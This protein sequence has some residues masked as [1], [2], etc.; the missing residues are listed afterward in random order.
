MA[1]A[2]PTVMPVS[3]GVADFA[4]LV[5]SHQGMVFS[6]AYHFLHDWATAEE[7]AQDVFVQLCSSL[8]KLESPEHILFWLR[9]TTV[10]RC[11]D[12]VR[13]TRR[14]QEVAIE[15]IDEVAAP[16]S[17]E[18]DEWM[19]RRLRRF[20]AAL[21]EDAR[22]CVILRYQEGLEPREIAAVMKISANTVKSRLQR[23]LAL[24]REKAGVE[25]MSDE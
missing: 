20:V 8:K 25:R 2:L 13:R 15:T 1:M 24:L 3:T 6:I 17:S 10:N 16:A 9:R 14:R 5:E 7:I 19:S 21:P 18:S 12:H 22:M 23:A 4:A 11:I